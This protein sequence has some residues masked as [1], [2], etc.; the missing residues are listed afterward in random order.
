MHPDARRKPLDCLAPCSSNNPVCLKIEN[1]FFETMRTADALLSK[2]AGFIMA[3]LVEYA[4]RHLSKRNLPPALW[5]LVGQSYALVL[6]ANFFIKYTYYGWRTAVHRKNNKGFSVVVT[7]T[8]TAK[9]PSSNCN[10]S[11]LPAIAAISKPQLDRCQT[12]TANVSSADSKARW[13]VRRGCR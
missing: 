11:L 2:F 4:R 1:P 13:E 6:H 5:A 9:H 8:A 12:N 3:T 7:L 10:D